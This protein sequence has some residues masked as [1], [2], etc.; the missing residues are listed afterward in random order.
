MSRRRAPAHRWHVG[1]RAQL[2]TYLRFQSSG[3]SVV[4]WRNVEVVA[5]RGD[6]VVTRY[7]AW[8]SEHP[9]WELRVPPKPRGFCRWRRS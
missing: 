5:V 8:E 2:S 1:D 4:H 3:R 9:W 6:R 7:Y